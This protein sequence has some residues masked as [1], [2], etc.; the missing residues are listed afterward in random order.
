MTKPLLLDSDVLIDYLRQRPQ[1]TAYL[2]ALTAA[3]VL[4]AIT[5]AELFSGVRDGQERTLLEALVASVQILSV[6]E[7]V[8][9][10]AGLTRRQYWTSHRLALPDVLIAATAL[11]HNATLVTL[12]AKHFPMLPDVLVPYQKP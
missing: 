4:S 1:V 2:E 10:Q 7:Q 9:T 12:N 8:A 11:V 3:P 5:V 6:E